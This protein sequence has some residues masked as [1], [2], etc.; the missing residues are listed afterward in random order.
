MN[1]AP[2]VQTYL[3]QISIT[4]KVGGAAGFCSLRCHTRDHESLDY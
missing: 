2:N 1:L 3:G 4:T